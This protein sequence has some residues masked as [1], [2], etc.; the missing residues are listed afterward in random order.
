MP[1]VEETVKGA[2]GKPGLL[3]HL[4]P[5]W[6]MRRRS[7]PALLGLT[8]IAVIAASGGLRS[9]HV[10]IGLLGLVDL[11]NPTTQVFLRYFFPFILTGVVYDSMRYYYWA[12][13]LGHIHVAEPY[14]RDLKYFG[15]QSLTPNE[16]FQRHHWLAL[17]LLCGFA[18]LVFVGEYLL[19]AFVLFFK[20]RFALLSLF[21]WS[22]FTVNFFGFLTYFVYPAAPPWYV[23]QYGLGPPRTDVHAQAAAATRFDQ[24]FGT[25]F[26]DQIYGRGIDVYGA[27]PSLHVAYPFL[28]MLATFRLT[29]RVRARIPTVMFYLLMCLSAVYLQHHYIVDILL[30]TIYAFLTWVILSR[31]LGEPSS[32]FSENFE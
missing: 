20:R 24:F 2:K 8:Y 5:H 9:D 18:Y 14:Y 19:T 25:H 11:Y 4:L 6:K 16:F 22:F 27:Y 13:V 1:E 28:V 10:W 12:G 17:D 30:G 32:E 21:G 3:R 26:F 15:I 29:T 31:Y 23:S 7:W